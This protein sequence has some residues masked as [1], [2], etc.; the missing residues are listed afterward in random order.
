MVS[1]PDRSCNALPLIVSDAIVTAASKV[2]VAPP[3]APMVT[4]SPIAGS[5][6]GAQFTAVAHAPS[7][8]PVQL[9]GAATAVVATSTMLPMTINVARMDTSTSGRQFAD[10]AAF[11]IHPASIAGC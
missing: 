5:L 4:S 10:N 2:T 8:P 3:A 1:P 11:S 9:I 7:L 6:A